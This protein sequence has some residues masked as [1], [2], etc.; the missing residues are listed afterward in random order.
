MKRISILVLTLGLLILNSCKKDESTDSGNPPGGGGGSGSGVYTVY[1]TGGQWRNRSAYFWKDDVL[2]DLTN[3]NPYFD[4]TGTNIYLTS[5]AVS[6]TGDVYIAGGECLKVRQD[7]S[8]SFDFIDSCYTVLWKNGVKQ[9]LNSTPVER[10]FM[11][12][13]DVDLALNSNND[14]FVLGRDGAA[15]AGLYSIW[16]NGSRIIDINDI[17]ANVE[18]LFAKG[19]DV[20]AC[21]T[22]GVSGS[23]TS[24]LWKNGV[25]QLLNG[26]VYSSSVFVSDNDDVYVGLGDGTILKNNVVQTPLQSD[27]GTDASE[28]KDIFCKGNDVYVLGY[29][30]G[31][32][33]V[34][35]NGTQLYKHSSQIPAYDFVRMQSVF[36]SGNDVY[37]SGVLSNI[38]TSSGG[39]SAAVIYKNGTLYKTLFDG[40]G[41]LIDA[42]SVFV[43]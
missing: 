20:Y 8:F 1:T 13:E 38:N 16:K 27:I 12:G 25:L 32:C 23:Q 21:G 5:I 39:S 29:A 6:S 11:R 37:V 28:I 30:G 19:N 17:D 26:N 2:T 15:G 24:A 35:K 33:I 14:V 41:I 34:W 31:E 36:I 22:I 10:W 18:K 3:Q 40:N 43:K 7:I 4:S 9:Y 42:P